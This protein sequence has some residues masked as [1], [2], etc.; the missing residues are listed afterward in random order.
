MFPLNTTAEKFIHTNFLARQKV[1]RAPGEIRRVP[2]GIISMGI[3]TMSCFFLFLWVRLYVLEIGYQMSSA[4]ETREHLLQD[5]R[6]LRIE[7]ASLSAPS[8]IED[9]ARN[10]LGMIIPDNRHIV[11]LPWS[12]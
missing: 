11:V 6:Q 3:I 5:N 9:I 7:R 4:L 10:K 12:K 8:R 2:L 1:A